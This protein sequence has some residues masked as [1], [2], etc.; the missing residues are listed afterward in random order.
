M[1]RPRHAIR[2]SLLLVFFCSIIAF[3]AASPASAQQSVPA[4]DSSALP[5]APA[6]TGSIHGTVQNPD[7]AVYEGVRISLVQP[8]VPAQTTTT[9]ADGGFTFSNV[10]P[11]PFTLNFSAKGFTTQAVTGTLQSGQSYEVPAITLAFA[12]AVSEVDVTASTTEISEAQLQIE[13]KQRVFG[14][15]PNFYVAYTKDTPP[16]T[17]KQKFRLAWRTSIDPVSFGISAFVAGFEQ[18]TDAYPGF[19]QG[20]A[21]YGKRFGASYTDGFTGNMIGGAI[22]P[23]LFHQ[24][25]RYFYKGTGSTRSRVLYAIAN[26]VICKGD[27]GHWQPNYS[28]ILGSLASGGLSN[29]YYPASDRNGIGLTFEQTAIDTGASAIQYLFQEFV[30]R[31][32]TPKLP[33]YS[34]SNP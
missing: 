24:D 30:V 1:T 33:S 12:K 14:I 3:P 5:N 23:V 27:N 7:G 32:L 34:Q 4:P 11:G 20:A 2:S 26:A 16:L 31:R 21:G 25:P 28:G 10:S 15:I 18:A 9:N 19:G 6:T 29:L 13:E 8:G 17:A 22:F